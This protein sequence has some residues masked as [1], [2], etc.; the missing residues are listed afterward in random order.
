MAHTDAGRPI[1]SSVALANFEFSNPSWLDW[2]L[3]AGNAHFE[4]L[5]K[6]KIKNLKSN[7]TTKGIVRLKRLATD[8]S[9]PRD[10]CASV[11]AGAILTKQ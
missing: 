2:F 8:A 1:S 4:K 10:P 6:Y 3:L 5:N 7:S 9:T 11:L